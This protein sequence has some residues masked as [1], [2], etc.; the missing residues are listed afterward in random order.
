[1]QGVM[2]KSNGIIYRYLF[3]GRIILHIKEQ[4]LYIIQDAENELKYFYSNK[5]IRFSRGVD[6]D[7]FVVYCYCV[8]GKQSNRVHFIASLS[9]FV[10]I[11]HEPKDYY[12]LDLNIQ[13]DCFPELAIVG[14]NK[15]HHRSS[16]FICHK[17]KWEMNGDEKYHIEE[18]TTVE[19]KNVVDILKALF[20]KPTSR[21]FCAEQVYQTI[22]SARQ[23]VDSLDIKAIAES[24]RVEYFD[25]LE[26]RGGRGSFSDEVFGHT[27]YETLYD[28]TDGYLSSFLPYENEGGGWSSPYLRNGPAY[29]NIYGQVVTMGRPTEEQKE[30]WRLLAEKYNKTIK[31]RALS[32]ISKY[33]S[34]EHFAYLAYE[35]LLSLQSSFKDD[36][37]AKIQSQCFW[38]IAETT[39][40]LEK[41]KNDPSRFEQWIELYN[42]RSNHSGS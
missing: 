12:T 39:R 4:D 22:Q 28:Y 32:V 6:K 30:Q 21:R 8:W 25:T 9:D 10:F 5:H 40:I 35:R 2:Y 41:I 24:A 15:E 33:N 27:G 36:Y 38:R 31:Q 42:L 16:F 1:M 13:D 26:E 18:C 7:S 19:S 14:L 3:I 20:Y 17:K 37:Q 34:E 29:R 23:I 11:E